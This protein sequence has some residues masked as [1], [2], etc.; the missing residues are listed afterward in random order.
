[1]QPSI[2]TQIVSDAQ[3]RDRIAAAAHAIA[4]AAARPV[5]QH[6]GADAPVAIRR[7]RPADAGALERLAALDGR[8]HAFARVAGAWATEPELTVLLGETEGEPAA[9]VVVPSGVVLADPFKESAGV[10]RLL[11]VR[12]SQLRAGSRRGLRRRA[13]GR[14]H[15]LRA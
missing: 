10:V 4:A 2:L 13:A 6:R 7:A 12:A 15:A 9:A 11:Q 5:A 1:M 3:S 14:L 8:G